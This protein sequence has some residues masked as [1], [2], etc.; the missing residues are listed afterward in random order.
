[1]AIEGSTHLTY[2]ATAAATL[3]GYTLARPYL[4]ELAKTI[5]ESIPAGVLEYAN[6]AAEVLRP[7]IMTKA[8]FG[9]VAAKSVVPAAASRTKADGAHTAFVKDLT[10]LNLLT[11]F[12][13]GTGSKG[14]AVLAVLNGAYVTHSIWT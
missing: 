14:L 13:W 11:P 7:D 10:L 5:S 1:M 4:D 12:A 9:L 8:A 6:T 3:V 2:L